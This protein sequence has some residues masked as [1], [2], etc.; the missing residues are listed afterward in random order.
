MRFSPP[1]IIRIHIYT[2]WCTFIRINLSDFY[3]GY[4]KSS[5]CY[6]RAST[7]FLFPSQILFVNCV[8]IVV[9]TPWIAIKKTVT[10]LLRDSS[11]I[12]Y[13]RYKNHLVGLCRR[14]L[15]KV[16]VTLGTFLHFKLWL[17][18]VKLFKELV[19][20]TWAFKS[21]RKRCAQ[22]EIKW[23]R[24]LMIKSRSLIESFHGR[25]CWKYGISHF[26]TC[27]RLH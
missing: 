25:I 12:E 20:L 17:L 13:Q 27:R 19:T 26:I 4:D 11:G 18:T 24:H 21:R 3:S 15:L 6:L 8:Y 2:L 10:F 5:I 16:Q 1:Y 22:A 23:F 7:F 14:W 9:E